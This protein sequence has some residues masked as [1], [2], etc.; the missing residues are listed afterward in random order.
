MAQI[1]KEIV[2][3]EGEVAKRKEKVQGDLSQAEPALRAAQ[4][5]SMCPRR[6]FLF[7]FFFF[8]FSLFFFLLLLSCFSCQRCC[9]LRFAIFFVCHVF[10]FLPS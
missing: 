8:F 3:R 10:R 9:F 7:A 6:F 2:V 1:A 4:E 5:A